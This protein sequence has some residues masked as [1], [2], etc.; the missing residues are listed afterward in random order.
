MNIIFCYNAFENCY[1]WLGS[2]IFQGYNKFS[3]KWKKKKIALNLLDPGVTYDY[4]MCHS[5]SFTSSSNK[6]C[7]LLIWTIFVVLLQKSDLPL[8]GFEDSFGDLFWFLLCWLFVSSVNFLKPG[9]TYRQ[10][11]GR[12]ISNCLCC[13]QKTIISNSLC[14]HSKMKIRWLPLL[15]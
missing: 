2:Y 12:F 5:V 14:C 10:A 7:E 9:A 6:T 4:E 11:T 8:V 3:W 1:L 15:T 13:Q